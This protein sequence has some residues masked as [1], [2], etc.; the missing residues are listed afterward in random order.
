MA[1][2]SASASAAAKRVKAS[3]ARQ[4]SRI[5]T[6][7]PIGDALGNI[8]KDKDIK[9]VESNI[10]KAQAKPEQAVYGGQYGST[11]GMNAYNAN[12][13]QSPDNMNAPVDDGGIA[14]LQAALAAQM[15]GGSSGMSDKEISRLISQSVGGT[16]DPQI[17]AIQQEMGRAKSRAGT[18]KADLKA[19]Y[20]DL[21]GYYTGHVGST[22]AMYGVSKKDAQQRT[23]GLKNSITADYTERLKE[24]VDMYKSLGIEAAAPSATEG[25]YADQASQLAQADISGNA[26]AQALAVQ[27]QGD[28]TYWNE[29]AGIAQMEGTERQADVITQLQDYLNTQG[30]SVAGLK[31]QKSAAYSSALLDAKKKRADQANQRQNETWNRMMDLARLK[32]SAAKSGGSGSTPSKGLTG[33]AAYLGSQRLA[34][35]FQTSMQQAVTWNQTPQAKQYYG[36]EVPNTPEEM[37]QVIRDNAANRGLSADDQLKLWQAALVYYN[38][39]Q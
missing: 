37:A 5:E 3:K 34:N 2:K 33:V 1:V 22:K 15:S 30:A 21:S 12:N 25:Q 31:G 18:A 17:K 38:K 4:R 7:T 8:L 10:G 29:G 24:Q 23:Q 13:P 20:N 16:Y 39:L 28:A 26:E 14:Q 35:E 27:E 6:P 9:T 11:A 19:L 32:Q 36:N